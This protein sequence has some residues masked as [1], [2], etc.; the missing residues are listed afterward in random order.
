M[1][2]LRSTLPP[3]TAAATTVEEPIRSE[4]NRDLRRFLV[5]EKTRRKRR[6]YQSLNRARSHVDNFVRSSAPSPGTR[7]SRSC[8]DQLHLLPRLIHDADL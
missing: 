7:G 2:R 1:S 6:I 8:R 5:P 4:E 3:G